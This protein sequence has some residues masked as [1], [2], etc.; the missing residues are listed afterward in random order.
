MNTVKQDIDTGGVARLYVGISYAGM[1]KTVEQSISEAVENGSIILITGKPGT[2]KST[3]AKDMFPAYEYFCF[4]KLYDKSP[5]VGLCFRAGVI[6]DEPS[7]ATDKESLAPIIEQHLKDSKKL[8]LIERCGDRI[9]SYKDAI[10]EN[11]VV[12]INIDDLF[13]SVS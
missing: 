11:S 2:G 13:E 4:E 1:K 3:L 12:T 7:I 8:V 10:G 9:E 6:L 5:N